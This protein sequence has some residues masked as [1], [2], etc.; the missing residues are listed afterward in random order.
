MAARGAEAPLI[1]PTILQPTRRTPPITPR[2][3]F[4]PED[5]YQLC[6]VVTDFRHQWVLGW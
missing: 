4:V 1:G 5:L 6:H 3:P 2:Y